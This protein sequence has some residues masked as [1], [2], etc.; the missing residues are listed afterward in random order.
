MNL[1][2]R[3]IEKAAQLD[4]SKLLEQTQ[5][6][7]SDQTINI[8]FIHTHNLIKP[9]IKKI[10]QK[11]EEI[12]HND[13][14]TQ[15]IKNTKLI[16]VQRRATNIRSIL[17]SSDMMKTEGIRGS[18]PC[19]Q[20]CVTCKLLNPCTSFTSTATG[21]K[22]NVTGSYTCKSISV[23]Y[24]ITCKKCNIQYI[25]QTGNSLRERIYGHLA[26]IRAKNDVKPVFRQFL[27][28]RTRRHRR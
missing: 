25:G 23:I 18:H 1:L 17:V 3:A 22:Y 2:K 19:G 26:D 28:R 4:R 24:L 5:T 20:N 11:F 15:F 27:A 9:P 12:L 13:P 8:P 7:K 14:T 10:L 6:D 21:E 16:V